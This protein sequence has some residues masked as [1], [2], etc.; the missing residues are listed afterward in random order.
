MSP[1][2]AM[3]TILVIWIFSLGAALAPETGTARR[4]SEIKESPYRDAKPVGSLSKGDKVDL[5]ARQ[6]G[7]Y[8][9]KSPKGRGWV[10]MLSIRRGEVRKRKIEAGELVGLAS[11]RAGTGRVV[12]TT[13]I[14]GL[15]EEELKK[16][17]YNESE[18][19]KVEA[20]KAT[21]DEVR[22][23]A[24]AGNLAAQKIEY[25]PNSD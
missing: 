2:R 1:L 7:W 6:G 17:K 22:K 3:F 23:F 14:R 25:L 9:V 15:T 21:A 10:R 5:L 20:L 11:G 8:Q 18:V 24:T 4:K 16:A 12:A 19:K 13:G